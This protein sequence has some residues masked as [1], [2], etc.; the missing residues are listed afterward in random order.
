VPSLR[1]FEPEVGCGFEG[2][3][4]AVDDLEDGSLRI[5]ICQER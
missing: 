5:T 3:K 2:E 4:R 1:V